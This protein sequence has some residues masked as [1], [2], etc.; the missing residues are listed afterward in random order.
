MTMTRKMLLGLMAAG[1]IAAVGTAGFAQPPEG[2]FSGRRGPPPG[3]EGRA[4]MGPE[5]RAQNLRTQL[6]I[7]PAQENAFQ[8]YLTATGAPQM[9]REAMQNRRAQQGLTA[10][11]KLDAQLAE[12]TQRQADMRTR[13]DAAKRFYTALSTDQRVIFDNLPPQAMLGMAPGGGGGGRMAGGPRNG[14]RGP[15]GPGGP[16]GYDPQ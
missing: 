5:Q 14:R 8:A 12:A 16:G 7:T 13:A 10:P 9:G 4:Q 11:Q 15:G 2:G 1:A 3:A 6:S